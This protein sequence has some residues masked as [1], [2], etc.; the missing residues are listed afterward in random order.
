MAICTQFVRKNSFGP[1]LRTKSES[2]GAVSQKRSR[3]AG[4]ITFSR[5]FTAF[6]SSMI[7]QI[8]LDYDDKRKTD[9][10]WQTYN[11]ALYF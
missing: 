5:P 9:P 11:R 8:V 7:R 6:Q 2:S 1:G 3:S 4:Q 10:V